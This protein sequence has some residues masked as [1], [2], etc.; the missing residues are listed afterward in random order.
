MMTGSCVTSVSYWA[1]TVA[2]LLDAVALV[3][4]ATGIVFEFVSEWTCAGGG[5]PSA[6]TPHVHTRTDARPR[7]HAPAHHAPPP[8]CAD[9]GGGLGI[10]YRPGEPEV[11]VEAVAG[12]VG[13][14][15]KAKIAQHA[16]PFTPTLCMEN[17]RY[18]TGADGGLGGT[19]CATHPRTRAMPLTPHHA[20]PLCRAVRLAR[21]ARAG[22]QGHVRQVRA[23][24]ARARAPA[25]LLALAHAPALP[26]PSCAGTTAWTRAWPT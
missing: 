15:W 4:A 9:I 22:G 6:R 1:E 20:P 8:P 16:L 13:G 10:P 7:A 24:A 26:S 12:A 2:A 3:H 17:G 25:R 21:R 5:G 18:V 23:P 19:E 14:A 11:D